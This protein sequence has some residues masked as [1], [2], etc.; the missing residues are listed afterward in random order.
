MTA[1]GPDAK[2]LSSEQLRQD[3]VAEDFSSSKKFSTEKY[4]LLTRKQHL[5][6]F[7][8]D[9]LP[10]EK[11]NWPLN[12]AANKNPF[13]IVFILRKHIFQLKETPFWSIEKL[14][15]SNSDLEGAFFNKT[16][17]Q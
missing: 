12:I 14:S 3:L 17:Y 7:F 16:F 15:E 4:L 9:Y 13:N 6:N 5:Q 8:N 10:A 2:G 1:L 11:K